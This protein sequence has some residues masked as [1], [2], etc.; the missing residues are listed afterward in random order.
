M[1]PINPALV[2]WKADWNGRLVTRHDVKSAERSAL[3]SQA[4][5]IDTAE[6]KRDSDAVTRANAVYLQLREAAGLSSG[7]A[8]PTD[9]WDSLMAE[10]IRPTS[11]T[12][13]APNT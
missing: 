13:D 5:A 11:G 4:R 8:K 10:I 2:A 3:R 9:A 1:W 7:G 12:I 6:A